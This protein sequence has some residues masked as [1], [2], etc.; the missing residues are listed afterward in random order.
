MKG[1]RGENPQLV[2]F[3]DFCG[4]NTPNMAIFNLPKQP[5]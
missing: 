4:I 3:V 2:V 5:Y 1:E